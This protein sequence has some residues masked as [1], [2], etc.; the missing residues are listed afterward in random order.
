VI[1]RDRNGLGNNNLFAWK[2]YDK[3]YE[4]KRRTTFPR[5]GIVEGFFGPPWLMAHRKV[6]SN[7]ARRG[8]EYLSVLARGELRRNSRTKTSAKIK[9]HTCVPRF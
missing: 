2:D 5:C 3:F 9:N 4:M 6:M 7:S 1:L 8:N